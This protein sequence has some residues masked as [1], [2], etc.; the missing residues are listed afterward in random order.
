VSVGERRSSGGAALVAAGILLS[1]LF[2]LVRGRLLAHY[3]G[4]SAV[5]DALQAA[6]RIPNILQNLFG[7]GVL[8]AS[9]IPVYARL[10]AQG[11]EE[12]A[13]KVA[14]AIGALLALTSTVLVLVGIVAAPYVIPLIAGGFTGE[15]R[16][17]TVLLVQIMF[18]GVGLLVMSAWALGVLNAHRKFFLSYASPVAMN[19][20]M[21]TVLVWR[22]PE[23]AES[24]VGTVQLVTLVAW[25]SVV[26]SMAQVAVQL[27]TLLRVERRLRVSL[28]V[29]N[30]NV[31]AIL[32][33]FLPV[34]IGR[35]VVQIS[36]YADGL[37]ASFVSN[38]AVTLLANA[39]VI[40]V[41]PVSLFGM[42]VSASQLPAMS[43]ELGDDATVSAAL[44]TRLDDGLRRIAFYV[45][46]SSV[47]FFALGD[48]VGGVL[49]QSGRFQAHDTLWL[50]SV[51]A[52]SSVGLLAGTLGRLYASTWYALRNTKVPLK[53]ALVRVALT[54]GLG[55]V[56]SLYLPRWIGVDA[57]WGA[58]GL[59]A[60][61]GLAAWVEFALLRRSI[62]ERIGAL[63]VESAYIRSL[64]GSALVAALAAL[65]VKVALQ[66]WHAQEVQLLSAGSHP[67][68]L[69][70][71]ALPL[72]GL[73]YLVLTRRNGI[74]EATA[75][76]GRIARLLR[77]S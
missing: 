20:V 43:G 15:K 6:I 59:T 49:Y 74:P 60:S 33:N 32:S 77:A 34:F 62:A 71:I 53:F 38:G 28:A 63:P 37:I 10:L 41:L 50:W 5:N 54:V 14:G 51:L 26:G 9:F 73:T 58:A 46:P 40:A 19:V 12:E 24:I 25:A 13:G 3:L 61:A 44:R 45:V 55:L 68:L 42:A 35:G 47:A 67:L 7:E 17:L 29:G 65:T 21:I 30:R 2:G 72:Y 66:R 70:A 76:S 64:W 56:A 22:G 8:S 16:D 57:R 69:G 1:R 18:P 23:L 11:D 27:P 48:I 52:G 4:V 39:Q 75:V 36:A 31:R